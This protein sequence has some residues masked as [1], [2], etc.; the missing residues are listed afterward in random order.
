[1]AEGGGKGGD[2]AKQAVRSQGFVGGISS[3]VDDLAAGIQHSQSRKP[4]PP[5]AGDTFAERLTSGLYDH[6]STAFAPVPQE[7]MRGEGFG[8]RMAEAKLLQIQ[9]GRRPPPPEGPTFG[10]GPLVSGAIPIRQRVRAQGLT[11][12]SSL[13]DRFFRG[14]GR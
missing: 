14:T 7:P 9:G 13:V 5:P 4:P 3:F 8:E 12:G 6:Y 11:S 1:M 10:P 2:G